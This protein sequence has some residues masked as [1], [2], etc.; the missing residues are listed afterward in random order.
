MASDV[1]NA[2]TVLQ[3]VRTFQSKPY[4]GRVRHPIFSN[5]GEVTFGPRLEQGINIA[6]LCVN[7]CSITAAPVKSVT[8][9]SF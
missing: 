6:R 1:S 9:V 2:K 3:L 7:G 8:H 5:S 4:M